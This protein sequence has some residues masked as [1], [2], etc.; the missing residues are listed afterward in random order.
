M[1][2]AITCFSA[3]MLSVILGLGPACA[4]GM[5]STAPQKMMSPQEEQKMRDCQRQA[6][7]QNIKKDERA[8]FVMDCM[9]ATGK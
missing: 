9:T 5:K 6:A 8:K 3:I 2:R 4:Q 7:Q 1:A